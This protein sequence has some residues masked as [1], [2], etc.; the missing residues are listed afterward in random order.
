MTKQMKNKICIV[1]NYTNSQT[2]RFIYLARL[3]SNRGHDVTVITSDFCHTTKKTKDK[4]PQYKGINVVYL[5]EEGYSSNV[6]VHRLISHYKWGKNVG[7]YLRENVTPDVVYCAVPS[8]T[9]ARESA[10]YCKSHGIPFIVD[11]QDLWP[12]AFGMVIKNKLLQMGF[13]PMKW[14]ADSIYASA[15]FIISV[16]DTYV[17]RALKVNKKL[18]TGVTSF[19]GNDGELFDK[20]RNLHLLNR[21]DDEIILGYVGSMS[22]SYDIPC[23]FDALA[24]VVKRGKVKK[25]IRFVLIGSGTDENK[26]KEY[27]KKIYPNHVF[28]GRKP[29]DIMV[30][31]LCD[32][33][34]VINPIVKGSVASIINKVGDYAMSGIPVINT[35]ES[36]EYR[37]LV[38]RYQCGINCG[39]GNSDDVAMAIE[40][41][42]LDAD[43]RKLMG[44]NAIRLAKE[45][46]DR[47]YSYVKIVE[48]IE[49]LV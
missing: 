11:I 38:E 36:P 24:K 18:K 27:G 35:Q 8:L 15:D 14:Y 28:C 22:T 32:C 21:M 45:R 39:C 34:I 33:D 10:D 12:E 29:Y 16:S 1:S 13:L 41:L 40:K 19:L 42:A 3:F 47:R 26:F 46:F 9:A 2:S 25:A 6:S 49:K 20:C 23:V 43:L 5:H 30:G 37:D 44:A 31:M 48:A 17:N 4:R 7:K